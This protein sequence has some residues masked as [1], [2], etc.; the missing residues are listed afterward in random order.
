MRFFR[1]KEF[2]KKEID[3]RNIFEF[4]VSKLAAKNGILL[5]NAKCHLIYTV[6]IGEQTPS[7]MAVCIS[8]PGV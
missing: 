8:T 4:A 7:I 5:S 3:K 1:E 2:K 6:S